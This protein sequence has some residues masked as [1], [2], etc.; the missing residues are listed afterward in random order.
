M[1]ALE[2]KFNKL[3][4]LL[5]TS[6]RHTELVISLNIAIYRRGD[7]FDEEGLRMDDWRIASVM[8]KVTNL[9]RLVLLNGVEFNQLFKVIL[10]GDSEPNLL[11]PSVYAE[12]VPFKLRSFKELGVHRSR[13]NFLAS[14]SFIVEL[15][16]DTRAGVALVEGPVRSFDRPILPNLRQLMG[17]ATDPLTTHLLHRPLIRL[18]LVGRATIL[19]ERPH[20]QL[21]VLSLDTLDPLGD[22]SK[23]CPNLRFF[24]LFGLIMSVRFVFGVVSSTDGV[25]PVRFRVF[26]KRFGD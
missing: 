4:D 2:T 6:S 7:V 8:Q 18:Y 12:V 24:G 25:L 3:L 13:Y 19:L 15:Q 21:E 23:V 22:L 17:H 20:P 26:W 14:Q 1:T 10:G 16:L 5:A 9:R 11:A